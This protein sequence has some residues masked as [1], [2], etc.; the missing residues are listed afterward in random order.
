MQSELLSYHTSLPSAEADP[1]NTYAVRAV[2]GAAFEQMLI[3]SILTLSG[4]RSLSAC[5]SPHLPYKH[6]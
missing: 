5:A 1:T 6:S 3:D 4:F 2:T